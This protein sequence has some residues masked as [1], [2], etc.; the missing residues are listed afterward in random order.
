MNPASRLAR[1]V[2]YVPRKVYEA[3]V[4][5]R[6]VAYDTGYL[7]SR[8]LNRPVISVGNITFGGTGKTPIVEM[9]AGWLRDEG[10]KVV[11]LTRGYGRRSSG[12]VVLRS[13]AGTL[14]P[15]A[16][17]VGGDEPAMLARHLPGV[18]VVVDADRYAAGRWAES[19]L[20]PDV[21][22]L[23]DG[24]QHLGLVR[25]VNFLV[26]DAT[27]PF[28]GAEMPPFGRL[29]EPILG[30]KRASAVIVTRADRPFDDA[31]IRRVV[32]GVCGDAMPLFYAFHD[33]VGLRSLGDGRS[34]TPYAFRKKKAA[35]LAAI[36]N[37]GVL[38]GDLEHSGIDVVSETLYED[39]HAY[40]QRDVD[41]AIAAARGAGADLM[42]TTAKDAV[43]L[44]RLD[45]GAL[46]TYVVE[47]AVRSE[48]EAM[49]KS[50]VLK[51]ILRFGRDR[52]I[53]LD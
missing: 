35:V 2:V 50:H 12:R 20:D 4:A 45:L 30:M 51:A 49:I 32:H 52:E 14:R 21:F 1:A 9:L 46:P 10:Y 7:A 31:S 25:D 13:E 37:P 42:L 5:L 26:V 28:G 48:Q 11:V 23:D 3:L 47:I 33:I 38:L 44:E 15:D 43:K 18:H 53:R 29:R 16:A 6:V 34:V 24:F 19:H 8:G 39:H 22:V 36:G 40:T 27:D 17:E 41:T